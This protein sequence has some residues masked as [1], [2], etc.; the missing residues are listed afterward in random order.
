MH[1]AGATLGDA[2]AL[3]GARQAKHIAQYP[4]QWSIAIDV[5]AVFRSI[6]VN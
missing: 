5:D 6:D 3:F 4:E 2:T 1:G